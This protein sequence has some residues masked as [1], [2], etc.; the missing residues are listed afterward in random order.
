[1]YSL[2]ESQAR[3][4]E[5]VCTATIGA[6]LPEL[7]YYLHALKEYDEE[8]HAYFIVG[9]LGAMISTI[10]LVCYKAMVKVHVCVCV[11]VHT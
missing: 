1:V 9:F 6:S 5:A 7:V 8:T 4:T 2:N 11:C 3:T 10:S